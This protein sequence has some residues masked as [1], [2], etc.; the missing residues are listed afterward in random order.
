L[1]SRLLRRSTSSA[2][3]SQM[4]D[5][6]GAF[7]NP[8]LP[9]RMRSLTITAAAAY[10]RRPDIRW[11]TR[12]R[13][14]SPT[15]LSSP[16]PRSAQGTR[17][18]PHSRTTPSSTPHSRVAA[19]VSQQHRRAPAA[20]HRQGSGRFAP[21]YQRAVEYPPPN[22][23]STGSSAPRLVP[24]LLCLPPF[25]H[26]PSYLSSNFAKHPSRVIS[27]SMPARLRSASQIP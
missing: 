10:I 18:S 7:P 22:C 14:S 26:A 1:L 11:P 27:R 20:S 2:L 23:I 15:S 5:T 4:D 24:D 8:L 19:P 6:P 17:I 21:L 25:S 9:K 16:R 12:A 3:G 13:S